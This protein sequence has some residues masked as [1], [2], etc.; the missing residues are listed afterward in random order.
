MQKKIHQDE[1]FMKQ[2]MYN[3]ANK[4][5]SESASCASSDE[6]AMIRDDV[7]SINKDF[8]AIGLTGSFLK[9]ETIMERSQENTPNCVKESESPAIFEMP[10][11]P[12]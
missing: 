1:D 3:M 9:R 6:Q 11:P 4:L 5:N 8:L 10:T 2:H 12:K 7:S